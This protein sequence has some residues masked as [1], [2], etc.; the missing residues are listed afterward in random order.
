MTDGRYMGA[1]A[2]VRGVI[3]FL[4]APFADS[5]VPWMDVKYNM[6]ITTLSAARG[7]GHQPHQA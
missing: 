4:G 7:P 5:K 3:G 6:N 1:P 2:T